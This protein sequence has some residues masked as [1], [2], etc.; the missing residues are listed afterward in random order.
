MAWRLVFK[1]NSLQL[2]LLCTKFATPPLAIE[3]VEQL[4]K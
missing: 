4:L 2:M 1:G 3:L